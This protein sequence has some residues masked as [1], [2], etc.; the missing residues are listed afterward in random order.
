MSFT[1]FPDDPENIP[2]KRIS[3]FE[4]SLNIPEEEEFQDKI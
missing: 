4:K 1:E 2:A 3:E